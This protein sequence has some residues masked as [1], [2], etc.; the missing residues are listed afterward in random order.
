M[1]ALCRD[2]LPLVHYEVRALSVRLPGHV[3]LDDLVSAGMAA[4]AAAA[5]AFDPS[6]GVPFARYAA[7]RI[8]GALLDELRSA[9]WASRS[10]RARA[11]ARD[12]MADELAGRLG[13]VPS[14]PELAAALGVDAAELRR[15]SS[16]LRQ[17]SVLR[18]DLLV[19]D[20]GA[21]PVLPRA[22]G[23][24]EQVLLERERHGYLR[25]AVRALPERLRTVVEGCFLHERP[26]R[27]VAEELGVTESRVSQM[28][29]EA[30][31]LLRDGINAHLDPDLV[32]DA[33]DGVKTRRRMAYYA[34][35]GGRSTYRDRLTETHPARAATLAT[36]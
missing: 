9:D 19:G 28:R 17:A 14:E 13:R 6:L 15:L 26:L 21:E 24:P 2:H 5:T 4:L 30:L 36:A 31:A 35:V 25:D 34:E 12:T 33:G 11:R 1:S 16:E 32:A 20:Q 10:L 8:R 22:E 23:T 29:T 7:R 27:E 3:V 18:L